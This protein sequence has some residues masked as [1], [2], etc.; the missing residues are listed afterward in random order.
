MNVVARN[1]GG[2]VQR[3]RYYIGNQRF[4]ISGQ[5]MLYFGKSVLG[6][7]K[8]LGKSYQ[9]LVL[10]AFLPKYY[11]YSHKRIFELK[12]TIF[13]VLVKVLPGLFAD[14]GKLDYFDTRLSPNIDT[15]QNDLQRS[16]LAEVLTFP[17]ENKYTFVEEY[18]LPQIL[19]SILMNNNYNG[20]IF[21]STKDYSNLSNSHL[22]SDFDLNTALFVSCDKSSN[23]DQNLKNT[24]FELTTDG[25]EK[26]NL[27]PVDILS[28]ME[29]VF[30]KNRASSQNNNGFILPLV[31][32][33]LH[34]KYLEKS[35]LD[36]I[37]YFETNEGKLELEFY[38]K[39]VFLM[40]KHVK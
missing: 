35:T 37:P 14:G 34:I 13:D 40:D 12:N 20:I 11:I 2:V 17:V 19:T 27:K 9:D 38:L 24:F 31:K 36:G 29:T 5:P 15:I 1:K 25:S 10:A 26:F 18:V 39:L 3:S 23:Y 28:Q 16:I 33:K 8:E 21:P 22:F 6:I 32:T 7:V 4:S 30:T